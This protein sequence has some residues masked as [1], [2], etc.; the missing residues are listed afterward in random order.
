MPRAN[1]APFEDLARIEDIA[2]S[3]DSLDDAS[4]G[5]VAA[6]MAGAPARYIAPVADFPLAASA[7]AADFAAM[8]RQKSSAPADPFVSEDLRARV[9]HNAR[10]YAV[11]EAS[12]RRA[13]MKKGGMVLPGATSGRPAQAAWFQLTAVVAD[14]VCDHEARVK[15]VLWNVAAVAGWSQERRREI[16]TLPSLC[17]HVL[18]A[19]LATTSPDD[20]C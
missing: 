5:V 2:D 7:C 17:L 12:L 15:L 11:L 10:R 19:M 13:I 4:R 16:A 14:G 9:T 3:I 20:G 6:V 8:L 1:D 18:P